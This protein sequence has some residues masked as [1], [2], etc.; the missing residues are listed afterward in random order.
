LEANERLQ[1]GIEKDAE[2]RKHFIANAGAMD[3]K[4]KREQRKLKAAHK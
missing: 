4:S 3:K 1:V 2:E